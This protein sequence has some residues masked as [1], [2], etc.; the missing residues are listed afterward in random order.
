M[1][2]AESLCVAI[3]VGC[4][5]AAGKSGV[6]VQ[7]NASALGWEQAASSLVWRISPE[8]KRSRKALDVKWAE[9]ARDVFVEVTLTCPNGPF[10]FVQSI[11]AT[12]DVQEIPLPPHLNTCSLAT[13]RFGLVKSPFPGNVDC[14]LPP[15][16]FDAGRCTTAVGQSN[17]G[18]WVAPAGGIR[19]LVIPPGQTFRVFISQVS[20]DPMAK[21]SRDV[22]GV[23]RVVLF[24]G[25]HLEFV[26]GERVAEPPKRWPSDGPSDRF[27]A[28]EIDELH[29]GVDTKVSFN[30]LTAGVQGQAGPSKAQADNCEKGTVGARGGAGGQGDSA[31]WL[32]LNVGLGHVGSLTLEGRGAAGGDG[33]RGGPGQQG[34]GGK[35]KR[36]CASAAGG[37][38]GPGGFPGAGGGPGRLEVTW[39]SLTKRCWP[40]AST[41]KGQAYLGKHWIPNSLRFEL[42]AGV[43]GE[44]GEPGSG[45][46]AGGSTSNPGPDGDS[47]V[48]HHNTSVGRL[49]ISRVSSKYDGPECEPGEQW[50][51]GP[52]PGD[53][54]SRY[55]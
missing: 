43:G 54:F 26:F 35:T 29:A 14:P 38:G 23:E 16:A 7:S 52:G 34:G 31:G 50:R 37:K 9:N 51:L 49:K 30:G 21:E 2:R 15:A 17:A 40:I 45:G 6:P 41:W 1:S 3:L 47:V 36:L 5:G 19:E 18:V 28:L 32:R 8:P 22:P 55:Q 39:R 33:G 42:V 13:A 53:A 10:Q 46:A 25:A 24:D 11:A 12:A 20:L 4:S 48:A 27:V 44:H